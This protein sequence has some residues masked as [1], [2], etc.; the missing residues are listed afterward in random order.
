MVDEELLVLLELL[1]ALGVLAAAVERVEVAPV[2]ACPAV[3]V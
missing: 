2:S 1:V 3:K